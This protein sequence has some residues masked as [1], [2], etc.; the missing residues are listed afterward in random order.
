MA[1]I[2]PEPSMEDIL[3]SIKRIIADDNPL[4]RRGNSP[5][6]SA[7]SEPAQTDRRP[8]PS[9]TPWPSV[10]DAESDGHDDSILELTNRAPS[11]VPPI[12]PVPGA[13]HLHDQQKP[14]PPEEIPAV[15]RVVDRLRQSEAASAQARAASVAATVSEPEPPIA[16]PVAAAVPEPAPPASSA[17]PSPVSIGGG[18]TV[19]ALVREMLRPMLTEWIDTHMPAIVERLVKQEIS[20]ASDE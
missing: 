3:A 4:P 20:G 19:E 16:P 8:P 12:L 15:S 9:P 6:A 5:S 13:A 2:R 1:D 7:A 18:M 10:S 11:S 14:W 17:S